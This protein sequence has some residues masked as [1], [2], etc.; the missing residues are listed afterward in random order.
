[1]TNPVDF[2]PLPDKNSNI[3]LADRAY[4]QIKELIFR[5]ALSPGQKIIYKDLCEKLEISRTPVINALTKLEQ[6]GFVTSE[7]YRGFYVK[8]IDIKEIADNFGVREALETYSLKGAIANINSQN[9]AELETRIVAHRE[10]MPPI[11]DKK[12]LYLDAAVH[13]QLAEMS[14]NHVLVQMLTKNLEHVYLRLALNSSTTKRLTSAADEHSKLLQLIKERNVRECE[15]LMSSH[16][17][18]ARDHIIDDLLNQESYLNL[19]E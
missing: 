2:S 13:I 12:K 9:L 1:M 4:L 19:S 16:I 8:P 5:R 18:N 17:S 11:Y 15:A 6:E 3:P 10:Y 14:D 7:S